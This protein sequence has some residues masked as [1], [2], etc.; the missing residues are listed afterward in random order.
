MLMGMRDC[1]VQ[2]LEDSVGLKIYSV[3]SVIFFKTF[4]PLVLVVR[5]GLG[6]LPVQVMTSFMISV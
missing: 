5:H 3:L 1:R 4:F 2:D 6:A